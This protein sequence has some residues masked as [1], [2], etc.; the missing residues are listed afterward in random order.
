LLTHDPQSLTISDDL[1][2]ANWYLSYFPS[3]IADREMLNDPDSLF[4]PEHVSHKS[5]TSL[6][7]LFSHLWSN[8]WCCNR[9]SHIVKKF[10]LLLPHHQ[11]P[12]PIN[13]HLLG[14]YEYGKVLSP[15][16][17]KIRIVKMVKIIAA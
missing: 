4:V 15:C 7:W 13:N 12:W 6:H 14:P 11:D 10:N 3:Q 9:W 5:V 8:E 2:I 16:G 17:F 1:A